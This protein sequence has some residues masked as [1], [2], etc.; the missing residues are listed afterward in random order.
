[1]SALTGVLLVAEVAALL[2]GA[3][4]VIVLCCFAVAVMIAWERELV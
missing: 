2:M 1:M 4:P 3:D